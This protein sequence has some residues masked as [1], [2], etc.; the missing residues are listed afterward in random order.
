MGWT[1]MQGVPVSA[2]N[3]IENINQIFYIFQKKILFYIFN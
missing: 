3:K 2:R 1:L